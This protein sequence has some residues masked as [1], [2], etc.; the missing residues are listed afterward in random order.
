MPLWKPLVV[1]RIGITF[2]IPDEDLYN[3]I[4]GQLFTFKEEQGTYL[5]SGKIVIRKNPHCT[6]L[7]YYPAYSHKKAGRRK[8]ADLTVGSCSKP[9]KGVTHKYF[10]LTLYPSQFQVGEFEHFKS[11]FDL[12]FNPLSYLQMHE[13]GTVNYLELA[14][15]SLSQKHHSFLPYRKG[16]KNS[17]IY[18]DSKTGQLG[19]TYIG[20]RTSNFRFRIYDKRKHLIETGKTPD[21]NWK[22]HTR[23]EAV[24]RRLGITPAELCQLDNPFT[25]LQIVDVITTQGASEDKD[26]QSFIENSMQ[27]GIPKALPSNAYQ[28]KKFRAL[29]DETQCQWWNPNFIWL[30]LPDALGVIAP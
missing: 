24:M 10:T 16:C 12:L 21:P 15:D 2:V 3:H 30:G 8:I 22:T 17:S 14:A 20:S 23:I 5:P 6:R 1:D 26:W 25:K 18:F 29:L 7:D 13:S 28:R 9:G 27:I 4:Y 19:T 11:N